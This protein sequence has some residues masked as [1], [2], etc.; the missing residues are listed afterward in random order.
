MESDT[1]VSHRRYSA[2]KA[3]CVLKQLKSKEPPDVQMILL[4]SPPPE[5]EKEEEAM[6]EEAMEAEG[7]SA[8]SRFPLLILEIYHRI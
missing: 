2:C 7:E 8:V 5:E 3:V 1:P 4:E 6:E